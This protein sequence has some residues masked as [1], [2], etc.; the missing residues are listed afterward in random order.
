MNDQQGRRHENHVITKKTTNFHPGT[1]EDEGHN[2]PVRVLYNEY[3][4]YTEPHEDG[5][6]AA[7]HRIFV[8]YP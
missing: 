6:E 5:D 1:L 2:R 7:R 3:G 8:M 4:S